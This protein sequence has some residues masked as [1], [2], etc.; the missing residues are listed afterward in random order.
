MTKRELKLDLKHNTV[1]SS[2]LQMPDEAGGL[3]IFA[4]GSGSSRLSPRNNYVAKILTEHHIATVLTDLL[5]ASEDSKRENR[6]NI[7]LLTDRLIKVTELALEQSSL[8][9]LPVG[10]FGASTGAAAALQAAVL[11]QSAVKAVVSRGGRPDL[12]KQALPEITAATLLIIGS[13][14]SDVIELNM[15]AFAMMKCKKEMKI[16]EGASHLFEEPGKLHQVAQLAAEWFEQN[17]LV[18]VVLKNN[19]K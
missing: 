9:Y 6:F 15:Q 16:V 7:A 5:T 12:A 4:H 14:D 19:T 3:V 1:L 8:Q 10:Y 17:L 18:P 11:L 13:L 2:I